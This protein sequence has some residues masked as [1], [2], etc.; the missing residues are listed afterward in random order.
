MVLALPAE[1]LPE[2]ADLCR[3]YRVEWSDIGSFQDSGRLLVKYGDRMVLDLEN[4]FLHHGMPRLHLHASAAA[5]P[6]IPAP[7]VNPTSEA[8]EPTAENYLLALLSH[9]NLHSKEA[10]IRLYDHEVR[11]MT[12]IKPLVGEASDGPSDAVVLKPLETQGWRGFVL[13]NGINPTYGEYDPYAMAYSAVDEAIRNAVAVGADPQHLA[14]LDNF[15]WGDPRRPETLGSLALAARGCYDAALHYRAPFISGKDSLNNEYIGTD[16]VRQ[17]IPGT[18]LISSI[19]IHPDIRRAVSMDVK[20]A[21]SRVYLV[22]DWAPA[23]AGSHI[24]LIETGWTAEFPELQH[25]PGFARR[26]PHLYQSLHQAILNGWVLSVHDLSEGGLAVAAAEM[27]LAGR[28]GMD[29]NLSALHAHPLIACFA[30]T[31]GCLLVEVK[32]Q[33][34]VAF[35]RHIQRDSGNPAF[36]KL[37]ET[38]SDGRLKVWHA[39]MVFIHMAVQDLL[40]AFIA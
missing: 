32:E 12:V 13:A 22:G 40:A 26:A 21:G 6:A 30:E 4:D 31:N 20:Q 19:A 3:A 24:G 18:L 37:G 39:G 9:P 10:I 2:L 23:L 11:G 36:Q 25:T 15:C 33:D 8:E 14:L 38:T 1:Y 7:P 5:Y 28:L 27:C 29:L 34:A 35:E 16:G 17:A